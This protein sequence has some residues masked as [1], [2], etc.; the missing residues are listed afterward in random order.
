MR[1]FHIPVLVPGEDGDGDVKSLHPYLGRRHHVQNSLIA[2]KEMG[3]D[4]SAFPR[5]LWSYSVCMH[6]TENLDLATGLPL[7]FPT[8]P[9]S[10]IVLVRQG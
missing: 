7:Y 9:P 1:S 8:L 3:T 10:T 6:E 4:K 2:I 5:F